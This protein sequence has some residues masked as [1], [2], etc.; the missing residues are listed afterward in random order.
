M[1]LFKSFSSNKNKPAIKSVNPQT[2]AILMS[3]GF[4]G[5]K[6]LARHKR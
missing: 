5:T 2:A 6:N 4:S 1:R 3:S